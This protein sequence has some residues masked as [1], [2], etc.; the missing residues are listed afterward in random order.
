VL[1]TTVVALG[2]WLVG[3]IVQFVGY[4]VLVIVEIGTTVLILEVVVV[5]WIVGALVHVVLDAITVP[6]AHAR[7]EDESHEQ[8][9]LGRPVRAG[10]DLVAAAGLEERVSGQVQLDAR[11]GFTARL[12]GRFAVV[13]CAVWVRRADRREL[14]RVE[15]LKSVNLAHQVEAERH[16]APGRAQTGQDLIADLDAQAGVG[17]QRGVGGGEDGASERD[18]IIHKCRGALGANPRPDV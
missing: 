13:K 16:H 9:A 8:T 17:V 3:A 10:H 12:H 1:G 7:L 5:L 14:L 11:N 4:A 6:I 18:P 15:A 2:P